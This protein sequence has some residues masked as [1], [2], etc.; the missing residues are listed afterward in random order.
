MSI[1]SKAFSDAD[2][3][4]TY[5]RGRKLEIFLTKWNARFG[6]RPV[7]LR[8]SCC[9]SLVAAWL[10]WAVPLWRRTM[11]PGLAEHSGVS[12]NF[13]DAGKLDAAYEGLC[14]T[15]D[16]AHRFFPCVVVEGDMEPGDCAWLKFPNNPV[17]AGREWSGCCGIFGGYVNREGGNG[18]D[19][20]WWVIRNERDASVFPA[21]ASALRGSPRAFRPS[22]AHMDAAVAAGKSL[23]VVRRAVS[24]AP[25]R[26]RLV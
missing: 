13:A 10:E 9:I 11:A 15:P 19:G 24:R 23:E 8:G 3:T 16:R 21:P 5:M 22:L 18:A 4:Q 2:I 12:L 7:V 20:I 1:P 26:L 17:L 25:P 14:I 6:C